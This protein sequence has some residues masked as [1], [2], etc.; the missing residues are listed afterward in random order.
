MS[1]FLV[2]SQTLVPS[3]T[4]L[5][6]ILL[7]VMRLFQPITNHPVDHSHLNTNPHH[8]FCSVYIPVC[9]NLIFAKYCH[10]SVSA[11]QAVYITDCCSAFWPRFVFSGSRF[12]L[13]FLAS[14]FCVWF[15]Y[16]YNPRLFFRLRY[17]AFL[18]F[19][20]VWG[21][22]PLRIWSTCCC[23][24]TGWNWQRRIRL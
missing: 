7:S 24:F 20:L 19:D 8:L 1:R 12:S 14:L 2:L 22:W 17:L 23:S 4:P 13:L 9:L 11:Y 21:W 15:F 16:G 5:P 6:R 3:K 10:C 18:V